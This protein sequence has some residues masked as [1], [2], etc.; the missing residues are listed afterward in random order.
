MSSRGSHITTHAVELSVTELKLIWFALQVIGLRA[1]LDAES[2]QLIDNL[3]ARFTL[4][5]PKCQALDESRARVQK[6]AGNLKPKRIYMCSTCA[7]AV[8]NAP[9]AHCPNCSEPGAA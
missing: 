6:S 1:P 4:M 8:V 7:G 2:T 9:G 5:I 3:Y